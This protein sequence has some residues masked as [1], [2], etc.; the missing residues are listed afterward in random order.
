MVG[1][2]RRTDVEL[3][4][5]GAASNFSVAVARPAE[6]RLT[7]KVREKDTANPVDDAEVRLGLYR[8]TTDPAGMA[9]IEVPKGTYDLVVWKVGYDVPILSTEVACRPPGR[10]RGRH[11]ARGRPGRDLADVTPG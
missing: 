5:D 7:V 9:A 10:G 4:H 2:V 8:A 11:R 6:H 1:P 3:P